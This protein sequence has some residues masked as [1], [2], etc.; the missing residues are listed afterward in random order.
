MSNDAYI[1]EMNDSRE[2][3]MEYYM[4]DRYSR[5]VDAIRAAVSKDVGQ[6]FID[7]MMFEMGVNSRDIYPLEAA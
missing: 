2:R 3:D 6:E 5:A 4:E 1:D 7:T